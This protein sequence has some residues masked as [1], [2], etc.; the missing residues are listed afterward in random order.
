MRIYGTIRYEDKR[1]VK[2]LT[3]EILSVPEIQKVLPASVNL[4]VIAVYNNKRTRI[5]KLEFYKNRSTSLLGMFNLY[6]HTFSIFRL[7]K[8]MKTIGVNTN[9]AKRLLK[10]YGQEN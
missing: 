4:K 2:D 10:I 8:L 5:K 1:F 3:E 9:E 7:R 6:F